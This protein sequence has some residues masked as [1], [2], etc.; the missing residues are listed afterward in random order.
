MTCSREK[1]LEALASVTGITGTHGRLFGAV[2]KMAV[3][4]LLQGNQVMCPFRQLDPGTRRRRGRGK[5]S[6]KRGQK[7]ATVT[8]RKT[9]WPTSSWGQWHV[10][11]SSVAMRGDDLRRY[12][13]TYISS[14]RLCLPCC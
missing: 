10:D 9:R 8:D 3:H 13:C 5:N 1:V 12:T 4:T 7:A 6:G 11:T 14:R 2:F